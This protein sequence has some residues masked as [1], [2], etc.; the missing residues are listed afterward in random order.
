MNNSY[1]Y[2]HFSMLDSKNIN[3]SLKIFVNLNKSI[4]EIL[5]EAKIY[6]NQSSSNV[7]FEVLFASKNLNSKPLQDSAIASLFFKPQD[8]IFCKVKIDKVVPL[9]EEKDKQIDKNNNINTDENNNV[10]NDDVKINN[11]NNNNIDDLYFKALTKYSFY[12][13]EKFV[14]VIVPLTGVSSIPKDNIVADFQ[15]WS[16]NIKIIGLNTNNYRFGVTRLHYSII[17]KD[18]KIIIKANDI[19]IKLKKKKNDEYWSYL[20]KTRMVGDN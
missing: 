8:D 10:K 2:F 7:Q 17:P 6:L 9:N 11:N 4:K 15:E 3:S 5:S 14:K 19:H 1:L 16:F 13:D 18:S 12:D 20:N